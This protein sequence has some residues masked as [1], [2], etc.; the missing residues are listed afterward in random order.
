MKKETLDLIALSMQPSE[1]CHTID[2]DGTKTPDYKGLTIRVELEEGKT[3]VY[4]IKRHR[5][6]NF[7][8]DSNMIDS[9]TTS[10]DDTWGFDR[11]RSKRTKW[12]TN[13][14]FDKKLTS[15]TKEIKNKKYT[16]EN[17]Y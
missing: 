1:N 6:S 13:D 10:L 2:K 17:G 3:K 12:Y 16:I 8:L 15:L 14:N 11:D 4:H 7:M 5:P 9:Y